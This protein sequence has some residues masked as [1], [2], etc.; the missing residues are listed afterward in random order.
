MF[1]MSVPTQS[2]AHPNQLLAALPPDEYQGLAPSLEVLSL[3]VRQVLY[4]PG[5]PIEYVYFP[6][7]TMISLVST[8]ENGTTIEVGLVGREGMVGIPVI[9]GGSSTT[10][11]AFV[12]VAGQA[13]RL[14]ADRLKTEFQQSGAL[15]TLLLRYVQ[16]FLT[17]VSQS[18]VCNRLHNLE[19]RLARWLLLVRDC[20]DADDFLLTQ[21]FIAQMLGTRRSGVTVAAGTL[22]QAG[23]IRYTRGRIS[24]VDTEALEDTACECY[25]VIKTE[26]ARLLNPKF[27]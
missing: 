21:E 2:S 20:V 25:K 23:M 15:Q 5:E 12:Q 3:P 17:Q 27:G 26:L 8:M 24:I 13:T 16:A 10:T 11:R 7:Q 19:E 9:L 22:Q 14:K 6:H 1:A 18:A 4:E